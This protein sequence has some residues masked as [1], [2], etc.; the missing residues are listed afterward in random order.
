[1]S[2]K[3]I[4]TAKISGD[5][6]S[7]KDLTTVKDTLDLNNA[8]ELLTGTG[9]NQS[10]LMFHDTR[11]IAAAGN[12]DLD[13]AGSLSDGFGATLTFARVKLLYISSASGNSDNLRVG[14]AA[15]NP[16][17]AFVGATAHYVK[18][19]KGGMFLTVAPDATAFQV[20]GGSYDVLRITNEASSATATYDIV[21]IGS[22]A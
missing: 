1:M 3:T 17:W 8:I 6:Q 12:D 7:A 9:A 20:T 10:D 14:A 5:Y 22:S 2:L 4:V 18:V 16:F 13:L 21:V 15:S 19:R 11:T